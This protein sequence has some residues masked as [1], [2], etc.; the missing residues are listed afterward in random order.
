M[1]MTLFA[2]LLEPPVVLP[3]VFR[4]SSV[5]FPDESHM[6]VV[7]ESVAVAS[8]AASDERSAGIRGR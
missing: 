4:T 1:R 6:A 7:V 2:H 5:L 8:R 3:R